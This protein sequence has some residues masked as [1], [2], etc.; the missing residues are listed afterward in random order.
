MHLNTD[1]LPLP[2]PQFTLAKDYSVSPR[3][4]GWAVVRATWFIDRAGNKD[5]Y[6]D[7]VSLWATQDEAEA[8]IVAR[9]LA[10]AA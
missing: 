5:V 1:H 10:R 2:A 7:D 6:A 4:D 8:D 9:Q 3:P